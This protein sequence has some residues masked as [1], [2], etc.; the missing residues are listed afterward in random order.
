M[1]GILALE[2]ANMGAMVAWVAPT[3]G[4]SRPLWRFIEAAALQTSRLTPKKA[5]RELPFP[6]GGRIGI[7]TADNSVGLRGENFD[8]VICDE[9]PQYA[10]E[11]WSDVIMPTMADR[12]GMA[13]LIGTPKGKNWFFTEYQRGM[14][15]GIE[16][17]SFNAPSSANPIPAIQK[18]TR[19][20]RDRVSERTY[21]QEWLA[22]F[23]DDGTLF[24]N[25]Q[26]CATAEPAEYQQGHD[27]I[28]G[29][30]WARASGGDYTVFVVMDATTKTMVKITRMVGTAFDVQLSR[31]R[32]LWAEYGKGN[33]IAEYN[34][35][36]MPLVEQLQTE[37][38]PVT[39][40]TTTAASKHQIIT[41]LELA[42]DKQ[43]ITV[44][45]DAVLIAELNSY[46]KKE[47]AGLPSYSAPSG[48]HDDTVMALAF[49]WNGANSKDWYMI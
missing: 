6:S 8:I 45:N 42:F 24:L 22:E 31:L 16:Q 25:V 10:P 30:D 3:Y 17:V 13:Y 1:A 29:V 49:A 18:A 12:D 41:A 21:R 39:A 36:G 38:I 14:A 48:M 26:A 32:D 47:R 34:S 19:L 9:A 43:E 37:G 4:N 5:E 20:A 40:F 28:I 33:V 7:Y 44:L 11:V 23:V 46:E 35:L 2:A 27:Y 15:D